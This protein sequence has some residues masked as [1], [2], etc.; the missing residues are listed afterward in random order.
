MENI[1]KHNKIS[2]TKIN[3]QQ[4]QQKGQGTDVTGKIKDIVSTLIIFG[5]A[6]GLPAAVFTIIKDLILSNLPLSII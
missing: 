5:T 1:H 6:F 2:N 4:I 3:Q